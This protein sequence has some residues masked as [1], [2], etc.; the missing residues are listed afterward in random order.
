MSDVAA[1]FSITC[2][3]MANAY[4]YYDYPVTPSGILWDMEAMNAWQMKDFYNLARVKV[5]GTGA[6]VAFLPEYPTPPP[7]YR[8]QVTSGPVARAEIGYPSSDTITIEARYYDE[9]GNIVNYDM[10]Y[11][12]A[13]YASV[14]SQHPSSLD[15]SASG[16]N[17]VA[18][19]Q[20][21]IWSVANA[22]DVIRYSW[23]HEQAGPMPAGQ[24]TKNLSGSGTDSGGNAVS[25]NYTPVFPL[26][27]YELFSPW[28]LPYAAE[29]HTVS[30]Q[31]YDG[32]T[33]P[34][35]SSGWRIPPNPV[36]IHTTS[37]QFT[38]EPAEFF[39]YA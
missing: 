25:W 32:F 28:L 7:P 5:A 14:H 29:T 18:F 23:A 21:G 24:T 31:G 17:T 11:G 1:G 33:G 15:L 19:T 35:T 16:T 13:P 30:V 36:L 34:L 8:Q 27:D 39:S 9:Y 20:N 3:V 6:F 38:N 10:G 12:Q 4:A 2:H 26:L 37:G 22:G